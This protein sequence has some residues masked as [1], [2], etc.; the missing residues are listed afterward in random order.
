MPKINSC[1]SCQPAGPRRT[2][3]WIPP[4]PISTPPPL[5]PQSFSLTDPLLLLL[6]YLRE[7][8]NPS[9]HRHIPPLTRLLLLFHHLLLHHPLSP[10]LPQ[11]PQPLLLLPPLSQRIFMRVKT[12]D[13]SVLVVLQA[14]TQLS[15]EQ[16]RILPSLCRSTPLVY[17]GQQKR[18]CNL[19]LPYSPVED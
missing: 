6:L 15:P 2:R 7:T 19:S 17:S 1:D 10:P 12:R 11:T 4:T 16:G 13:V 18:Q 14:E 9:S 5:R 8:L 3:T